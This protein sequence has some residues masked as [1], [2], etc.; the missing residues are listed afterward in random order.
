MAPSTRIAQ[1]MPRR[2]PP[3]RMREK[4]LEILR[5]PVTGATLALKNGRMSGGGID[6]GELVSQATGHTYSI[7]RGIPRFVPAASYAESFG[8]QWNKYR[9]VQLDSATRATFSRRRF[10]AEAGWTEEELEG[11]W[12]LDAGCGA[13]RFAE[14][15]AMRKPNLV[16]MDL[17]SAVE[18]AKKTLER[19]PNAD[20]V[21]ASLF[22]PPFE[23]GTFDFVYCIG[24]IQHTP[25][26]RRAVETVVRLAK[27]GGRFA[28]TIYGRNPWTKFSGKY[29]LRPITRR[30]PQR[31]LLQMIETSMPVLFPVTDALFRVPIVGKLARFAIPVANWVEHT[32]STRESRYA[33]TV[34][35]T[36]DA[37]SPRYDSPMNWREVDS[38][39]KK[40][41]A[42]R[43]EFRNRAPVECVGVR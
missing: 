31:L 28:M 2:Y 3:P 25:D 42:E 35:D 10:D 20:V 4:L 22:E 36:F 38:V 19:F 14:I 16:A 29:M 37:L 11:R 12:C 40:V 21:Q 1:A 23:P 32:E 39:L 13:G 26:P 43:W 6:E 30:L 24:V 5:E 8:L 15:A 17:S 9:R 27:P 34:L 7:V 33:E 18:A 41:S